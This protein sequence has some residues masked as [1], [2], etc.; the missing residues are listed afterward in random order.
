MYEPNGADKDLCL[1]SE[2]IQRTP[3]DGFQVDK[4]YPK[5]IKVMSKWDNFY[6]FG[7]TFMSSFYILFQGARLWDKT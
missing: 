4:S 1:Y 7:I 6:P 5:W 2:D 3:A